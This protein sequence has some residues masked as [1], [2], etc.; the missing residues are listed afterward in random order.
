MS[1]CI[2]KDFADYKAATT[3]A[4]PNQEPDLV[5]IAFDLDR[6]IADDG[7]LSEIRFVSHARALDWARTVPAE[8]A[9]HRLERWG[10][11]CGRMSKKLADK[12]VVGEHLSENDLQLL[13]Q[14]SR[15]KVE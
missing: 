15:T 7:K 12:A 5:E 10:D 3:T 9:S 13:W 4:A 2:T 6:Y 8:I 14:E 11:Y 1:K